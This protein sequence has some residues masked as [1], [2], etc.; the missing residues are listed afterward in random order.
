MGQRRAD[1]RGAE[2]HARAVAVGGTAPCAA[3]GNLGT[4]NAGVL[5]TVG[6]SQAHLNMQP[7]LTLSFC[8]A[9]QGISPSA[10]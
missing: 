7:F 3:A 9:L 6:G 5:G 8:I 2:Q 4:M 10:T 1:S